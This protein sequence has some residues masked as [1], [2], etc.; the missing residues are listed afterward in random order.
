MNGAVVGVS[1]NGRPADKEVVDDRLP[2]QRTSGQ[3]YIDACEPTCFPSG[4]HGAMPDGDNLP[5]F[6]PA[7]SFEGIFV[8]QSAQMHL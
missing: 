7:F 5:I 6:K 8:P 1:R 3:Q 2:H 4:L